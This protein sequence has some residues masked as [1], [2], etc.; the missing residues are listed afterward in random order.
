MVFI[1]GVFWSMSNVRQ[2][3]AALIGFAACYHRSSA[4][5]SWRAS[6]DTAKVGTILGFVGA[7]L[8]MD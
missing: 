3:I 8:V 6:G 1:W 2:P 7:G 5:N 4:G